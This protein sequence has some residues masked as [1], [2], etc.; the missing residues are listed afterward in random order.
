MDRRWVLAF[1]G[2]LTVVGW[3]VPWGAQALFP[4]TLLATY[5]H[6][7]GHGL[8]ALLLGGE[9][10]SLVLHPDG[11]GT[12]FST[13]SGS[14]AA[15]AVAAGGLLGPSILGGGL[16]AASR[17]PSAARW[18]LL[19]G[20]IVMAASLVLVVRNGFGVAFVGAGAAILI[21][22]ARY[23]PRWSPFVLRLLAVQMAL[24]IFRDVDYMFS[25][26]ALLD[27]VPR[28]SDSQAMAE[29]LFLPYWFWGGLTAGLALMALGLGAWV[30]FRRPAKRSQS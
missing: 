8:T 23:R 24:S 9:F 4:F 18:W 1:M 2:M 26:G 11:S 3:Q 13:N 17:R 29:A 16:L 20:G 27:G 22:V 21:A 30:A 15:A 12:A 28:I 14:L 6:E 19:M 5:V 7:M 25:P 10:R